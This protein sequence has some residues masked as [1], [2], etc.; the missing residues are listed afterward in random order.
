[1]NTHK[2]RHT[3]VSSLL[4]EGKD[5]SLIQSLTGHSSLDMLGR[6]GK[7]SEKE[8]QGAIDTIYLES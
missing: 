6:Y 8:K 3:F 7:A 2:C 1:V 5:I 4:R